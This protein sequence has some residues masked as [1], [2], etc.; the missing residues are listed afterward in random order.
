MIYTL[1]MKNDPYFS[2][3]SVSIHCHMDMV[4]IASS[5]SFF[6]FFYIKKLEII[7]SLRCVY[8]DLWQCES[9]PMVSFNSLWDLEE[10]QFPKFI[11]K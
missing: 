5:S 2:N 6:L 4:L 9:L 8:L 10:I 11:P 1:Y 7:P 3:I